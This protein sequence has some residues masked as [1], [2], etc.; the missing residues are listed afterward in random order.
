MYKEKEQASHLSLPLTFYRRKGARL[1]Q[2]RSSTPKRSPSTPEARLKAP[3][4]AGRPISAGAGPSWSSSGQFRAIRAS[5]GLSRF[6]QQRWVCP[7]GNVPAEY[8]RVETMLVYSWRAEQSELMCFL[9]QISHFVLFTD[10]YFLTYSQ[11]NSLLRIILLTFFFPLTC[12]NSPGDW[13]SHDCKMCICTLQIHWNTNFNSCSRDFG[14]QGGLSPGTL[15]TWFLA[16]SQQHCNK[17][18]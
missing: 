8:P 14:K 10:C 4:W 16:H 1:W 18:N 9:W 13:H 3:P 7:V 15:W 2:R 17:L 12:S 11:M 6:F 5:S